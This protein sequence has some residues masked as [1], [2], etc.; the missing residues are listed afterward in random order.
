[1]LSTYTTYTGECRKKHRLSGW[2]MV[3]WK[4]RSKK[5]F[6]GVVHSVSF[7]VSFKMVEEVKEVSRECLK[8]RT[9]APQLEPPKA[10]LP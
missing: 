2:R 9:I 7:K 3:L 10:P 1:M 4:A 6:K 5:V 8:Y